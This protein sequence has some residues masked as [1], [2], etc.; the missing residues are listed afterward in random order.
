M[1]RGAIAYAVAAGAF[2]AF[3][4]ATWITSLSY[5]SIAAATTLVTSNPVWISLLSWWW[6]KE[7]PTAKT[8]FGIAIALMGGILISLGGVEGTTTATNPLLGNF[9]ALVGSWAVSFY[10]LLGRQA[11]RQG[12]G[13][14]AYAIV[15]YGTAALVLLPLP[16]L[17]GASYTGY[18]TLVYFYILLTALLPQLLGHTSINWA[19]RWVSPTLITLSILF[20]PVCSSLLGYWLFAEVPTFWLLAGAVLVLIGVAIATLGLRPLSD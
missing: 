15:A 10:L 13:V 16:G 20:E 5:T 12:L 1:S 17:F 9:L 4:F 11:Q 19:L 14:G 7:K 3:H 6:F 8:A 2:L 18:P